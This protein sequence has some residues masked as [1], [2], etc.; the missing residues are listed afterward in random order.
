LELAGDSFESGD[1]A[2]VQ[3]HMEACQPPAVMGVK[4]WLLHLVAAPVHHRQVF[5][6]LAICESDP[7]KTSPEIYPT[8]YP[9]MRH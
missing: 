2:A 5:S 1:S 6:D 9:K 8:T 4:W 3:P 7:G